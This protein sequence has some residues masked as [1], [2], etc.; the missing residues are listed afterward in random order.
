MKTTLTSTTAHHSLNQSAPGKG[1]QLNVSDNEDAILIVKDPQGAEKLDLD[2][3]LFDTYESIGIDLP[4]AC[5]DD[6]QGLVQAFNA[7]EQLGVTVDQNI[8]IDVSVIDT[9]LEELHE[10]SKNDTN[11]DNIIKDINGSSGDNG[12]MLS[13]SYILPILKKSKYDKYTAP[14]IFES[15][16][17][18]Q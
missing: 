3:I 4:N 16:C 5:K 1:L 15:K 8:G 10:T 13:G 12:R 18:V 7:S 14:A 2:S 6:M 11:L 9:D 17:K